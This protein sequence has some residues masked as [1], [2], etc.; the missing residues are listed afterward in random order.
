MA[1]AAIAAPH[2]TMPGT[3]LLINADDFGLTPGV[4][5]AIAELHAAGALPSA[6]LMARGAAFHDAVRIAHTHPT[7]DVGC[8]VVLV[9]GSPSAPHAPTL[10]T[11]N[12]FRISLPR[13]ILDLQRGRISEADIE[14]EATAQI[15]AI[16]QQGLTVT[17]VDTHKHTH[18]FPRVARPL[19]RAAQACGVPSIRNPFE[20]A[21]SARLTRGPLLRK[22]EVAVLRNFQRT[23]HRLTRQYGIAT[24]DGCIGVSATGTLDREN[25]ATL[26]TNLPAGTWELVCHPGYNDTDLANINTRLRSTRDTERE[27]LL[28][29]IPASNIARITFSDL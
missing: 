17:H 26:L 19:L 22:F 1:H 9:D 21:W 4:N 5:R 7:L 23:F 24:A 27:A 18:L 20:P 16:Q 28:S 14:H 8:H 29:A 15:H 6:T 3:R 12:C 13:F 11:G 25:L 10:A 2:P